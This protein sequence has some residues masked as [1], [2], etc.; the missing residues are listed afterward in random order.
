[1]AISI[2]YWARLFMPQ[3]LAQGLN[4]TQYLDLTRKTYGVAY[5]RTDFLKDWREME[6]RAEKRDPLRSIPKKHRPT[7]KTITP[8][9]YKQIGLYVYR[10]EGTGWDEILKKEVPVYMNIA[11]DDL[12]TM[13]EAEVEARRRMEKYKPEVGVKEIRIAS[14]TRET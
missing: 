12:L 13:A 6:G 11:S 3:A 8:S 14:I 9:E 10:Y 2:R 1:M 5:R 7:P 4:V